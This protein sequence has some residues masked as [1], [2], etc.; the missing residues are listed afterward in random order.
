MAHRASRAAIAAAEE[1]GRELAAEEEEWLA[2]SRPG[3]PLEAEASEQV[4]E[5]GQEAV[6]AVRALRWPPGQSCRGKRF[7]LFEATH[8]GGCAVVA[9]RPVAQARLGGSWHPPKGGSWKHIPRGFRTLDAA[10]AAAVRVN[11]ARGPLIWQ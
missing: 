6:R 8:P 7:Y 3:I 1:L 11:G 9:G 2:R 4:Q 5:T 10:E